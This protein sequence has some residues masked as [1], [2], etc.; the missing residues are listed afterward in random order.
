LKQK[1]STLHLTNRG[2][3]EQVEGLMGLIGKF[4]LVDAFSVDTMTEDQIKVIVASRREAPKP[5]TA[6]PPTQG[7]V[8]PLAIL[9]EA[10][11]QAVQKSA[12]T[13]YR[14]RHRKMIRRLGELFHGFTLGQGAGPDCRY[15]ALITDYNRNGR[16]L[17]VEVK[18]DRDKGSIRIAIGQLLDYRRFVPNQAATD[19]AILTISPP[20]QSHIEL[21]LDLR[22]TALWFGDE[23]CCAISG[24]GGAWSALKTHLATKR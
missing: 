11:R 19:L 24:K 15:D 14:N 5:P 18:P 9:D 22:I 20:T 7:E 6:A 16:D 23:G 21:M 3:R 4:G 12:T 1:L 17:L 8:A 10:E 13:T 2:L